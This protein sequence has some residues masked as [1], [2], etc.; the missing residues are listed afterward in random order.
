MGC[1]VWS[2]TVKDAVTGKRLSGVLGCQDLNPL[3]GGNS[4]TL[5][6]PGYLPTYVNVGTSSNGYAGSNVMWPYWFIA[7]VIIAILAV[8]VWSFVL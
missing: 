4:Y 6:K 7:L 8:V 3:A 5:T 1:G 2:D